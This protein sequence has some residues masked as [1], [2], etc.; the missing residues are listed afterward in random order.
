MLWCRGLSLIR[1]DFY[2]QAE[3][4]ITWTEI[5]WLA[6]YRI[7]WTNWANLQLICLGW[8]WLQGSFVFITNQAAE[9]TKFVAILTLVFAQWT[10]KSTNMLWITTLLTSFLACMCLM[11]IISSLF[12]FFVI[13]LVINLMGILLVC[14]LPWFKMLL[15]FSLK[16]AGGGGNSVWWYL[17]KCIWVACWSLATCLICLAVALELFIFLGK[18]VHLTCRKLV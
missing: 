3:W 13:L 2:L 15:L 7:W 5:F 9:M 4:F 17:I 6:T 10:P 16:F 1:P 11:T 8:S 12:I 14:I 18:M